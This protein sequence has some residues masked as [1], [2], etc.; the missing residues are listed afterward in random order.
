MD[1]RDRYCMDV[2]GGK[3]CTLHPVGE[4]PVRCPRQAADGSCGIYKLRYSSPLLEEKLV[5]VGTWRSKRGVERP[6]VCGHI[7]NIIAEGHL[8]KHVADVCCYAHPELLEG[9][10]DDDSILPG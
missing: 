6:F 4:E 2:C 9:I 7:E 1:K 10:G 5:Q 8:P 3:C